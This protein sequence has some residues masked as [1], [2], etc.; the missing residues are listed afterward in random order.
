M[1]TPAHNHSLNDFIKQSKY[2]IVG[3]LATVITLAI[4]AKANAASPATLGGFISP[5]TI[6]FLIVGIAVCVF[7]I[8]AM[9]TILHEAADSYTEVE[10]DTD[11]SYY[12]APAWGAA[13]AGVIAAIVI[14]SYGVNPSFFYLG[15]VLSMLSP[16]AILY[17]MLQDIKNFKLAHME[18][19][20]K[21]NKAISELIEH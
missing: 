9:L 17:C 15:P 8:K 6:I 16:I 13:L 12:A 14:W 7:Y 20:D 21:D 18:M 10:D 3:A 19:R 2:F 4:H 5:I 1:K 11:G